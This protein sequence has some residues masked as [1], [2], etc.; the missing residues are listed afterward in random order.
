MGRT[1]A[2]KTAIIVKLSCAAMGLL[3]LAAC[4][5]TKEFNEWRATDASNTRL[6][7]IMVIALFKQDQTRRIFEDEFAWQISNQGRMATRSYNLAP[8]LNEN[9]TGR[10][11]TIAKAV[12]ADGILAIRM[13]NGKQHAITA[14]ENPP[15]ASMDLFGFLQHSW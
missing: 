11:A 2:G 10:I 7:N 13:V 5:T 8:S 14:A 15:P 3:L 9:T 12:G 6:G 1:D 4:T